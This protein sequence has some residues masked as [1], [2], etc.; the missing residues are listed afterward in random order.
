MN[1]PRHYLWTWR[2]RSRRY[3]RPAKLFD[4]SLLLIQINNWFSKTMIGKLVI[5][6]LFQHFHIHAINCMPLCL[7]VKFSNC[8]RQA[9]TS[10]SRVWNSQNYISLLGSFLFLHLDFI[11][12]TILLTTAYLNPAIRKHILNKVSKARWTY[13]KSITISWKFLY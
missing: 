9:N 2:G 6:Q 11:S 12:N 10:A 8:S 5:I 7:Q 4:N 3:G 13:K 1:Q